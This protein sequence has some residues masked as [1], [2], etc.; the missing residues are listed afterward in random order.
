MALIATCSARE[1][2][3]I[4][5]DGLDRIVSE[6]WAELDA[7]FLERR[8]ILGDGMDPFIRDG[9][10]Y[11][12]VERREGFAVRS[13]GIDRGGDR[14][15]YEPRTIRRDGIESVGSEVETQRNY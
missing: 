4:G 10:G 3:A 8:T 6:V 15:R 14:E 7:E 9:W 12:Y 5:D 13:N 1:R 11:R 2:R